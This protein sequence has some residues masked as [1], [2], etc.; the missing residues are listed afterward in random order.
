MART[1]TDSA[2]L[3]GR[4]P[5]LPDAPGAAT[6]PRVGLAQ[7]RWRFFLLYCLVTLFAYGNVMLRGARPGFWV[8]P[9]DFTSFY[10][11]A[12]MLRQGLGS[13][14]YDLAVQAQ[15]Q[16]TL[17]RPY[18]WVFVDGLLP[19]N[20]PPF[21]AI[22][23]VPL[24]WV[25]LQWAFILWSL[26]NLALII[27]AVALLLAQWRRLSPG[28]LAICVVIA[29]TFFP[30]FQGLF[31][32]QSS[33]LVLLALTLTYVAQARKHEALSGVALAF[34]LVKPQLLILFV[35]WLLVRRRWRALLAFGATAIALLLVS[36]A[37]TGTD[38]LMAYLPL[39]RQ[40]L[41]WDGRYGITPA[42]MPNLRGTVVRLSHLYQ[43]W[44]GSPP[45][46][47]ATMLANALFALPVLWLVVLGLVDLSTGRR[48][49]RGP[50]LR[51]DDQRRLA[52][53][54]ASLW[55][56]PQPAR[57]GWFPADEAPPFRRQ[58]PGRMAYD[59]V[60]TCRA[61][62]LSVSGHGLASAG[63]HA[64]ALGRLWSLLR[65]NWQASIDRTWWQ[66]RGSRVFRRAALAAGKEGLTDMTSTSIR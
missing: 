17:L 56:R 35:L 25:S 49:G 24:T 54:P 65:W 12:L 8:G 1:A 6:V 10:T 5:G 29:L 52:V 11:G 19:Y 63:G 33:F 40:M 28:Y 48:G 55:P 2:L 53:E 15:V 37:I 36:W 66:T 46:T 44:H 31:N 23:F 47:L 18:G 58:A 60:G 38:G 34:G 4:S 26:A 9:H 61:I 32:G 20:Y 41:A 62:R 57:P 59:R 16:Q 14:L 3:R 42:M 51:P 27:T 39:T 7:Q 22:L 50:L 45:S 30:V 43:A 13:R 21:L 64:A